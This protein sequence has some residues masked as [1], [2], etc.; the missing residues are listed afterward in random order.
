MIGIAVGIVVLVVLG[1]AFKSV[2][3]R[4]Q[5]STNPNLA[6]D[7]DQ[8]PATLRTPVALPIQDHS[9]DKPR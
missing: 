4:D 9:F 1:W 6:E 7:M 2:V 8:M 5:R 3:P